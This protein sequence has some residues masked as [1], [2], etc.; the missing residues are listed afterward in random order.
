[1]FI[2]VSFAQ[3]VQNEQ[4]YRFAQKYHL[5]HFFKYVNMEK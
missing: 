3:N 4:N 5:K 1:M 2:F